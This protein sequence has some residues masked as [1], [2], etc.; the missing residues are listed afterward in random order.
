MKQK[1]RVF[2]QTNLFHKSELIKD[3]I[4]GIFLNRTVYTQESKQTNLLEAF[5]E[6]E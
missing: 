3:V 6:R 4:E 5:Q 1:G 2:F